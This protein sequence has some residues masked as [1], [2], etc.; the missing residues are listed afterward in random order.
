MQ[1]VWGVGT[2]PSPAL[3]EPMQGLWGGEVLLAPAPEK[4]MQGMR[5]GE[6]LPAPPREE[7]MQGVR[8]LDL[9]G[10]PEQQRAEWPVH[11]PRW[12]TPLPAA[13]SP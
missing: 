5:G 9:E 2:L 3:K 1:A 6:H 10:M 7:P 11:L 8:L 4:P 12:G 13:R